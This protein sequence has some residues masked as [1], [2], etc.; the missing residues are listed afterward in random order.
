M[1]L[2]SWGKLLSAGSLFS[3]VTGYAAGMESA[4]LLQEQG[5]LS[6]GDYYRHAALTR[7]EGLRVRA[8]QTMDYISAGVEIVGTPQLVLRETLSKSTAE[9][10]ALEVTGENVNILMN[11]KA[12]IAQEEG[13]S[14]LVSGVLTAAAFLI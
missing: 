5:A 10:K 11:R 6:R 2:S 13:M 3:G 9:A 7:E 1:A 14:S 4:S 8:K 12:D